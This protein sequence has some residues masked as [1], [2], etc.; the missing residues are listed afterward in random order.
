MMVISTNFKINEEVYMIYKENDVVNIRKDKVKSILIKEDETIYYLENFC[1]E[2]QEDE[3]ISV[4][5]DFELRD[6]IMKLI[7]GEE[8]D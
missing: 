1:D 2:V 5:Y 3:L 7:K 6:K 8:N 4:E